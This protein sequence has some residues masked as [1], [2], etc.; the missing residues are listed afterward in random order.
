[1]KSYFFLFVAFAVILTI[2]GCASNQEVFKVSGDK[3]NLFEDIPKASKPEVEYGHAIYL[4]VL[5]TIDI[6]KDYEDFRRVSSIGHKLANY[7]E[8]KYLPYTFTVIDDKRIFAV[9]TPG[10]FVYISSGLIKALPHE[11]TI[12]AVIAHELAHCQHVK[13]EFT[14]TKRTADLV[15]SASGYASKAVGPYGFVLPKGLKLLNNVLLTDG[16]KADR[17]IEADTVAIDLLNQSGYQKSA[18]LEFVEAVE[19]ADAKLAKKLETYKKMRPTTPERI[20]ALR[21]LTRK[22]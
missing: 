17:V 7:V 18:L 8:R 5:S 12:A 6:N 11:R 13:Q 22:D 15:Q 19:T 1:M 4:K 14:K 21:K 9:S 10:G 20:V 16:S 2:S 3:E